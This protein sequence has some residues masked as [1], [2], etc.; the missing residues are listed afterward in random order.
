[1]NLRPVLVT[2]PAVEPVT[3]AEAKAHLRVDISNDDALITAQIVAARNMAEAITHRA[4][5]TQTWDLYLDSWPSRALQLPFPPL[6]SVTSVKYYSDSAA[7]QTLTGSNYQ[8]D[9]ASE[10]GR[11]ILISGSSWPGDSLR[12]AN[13]VIVRFVAG[14]GL[15][16]AV[17]Q[18]FKQ[19]IL[20]IVG[21]FYENRENAM[22]MRLAEAPMAAMALLWQ[23]RVF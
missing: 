21:Q 20:L 7:E 18:I 13:G 5:V 4:F 22:P 11:L 9:I 16:A 1:M 15:A 23:D 10:P 8:V 19:A 17:P 3:L 2:A 6:Q 12:D 14:Y